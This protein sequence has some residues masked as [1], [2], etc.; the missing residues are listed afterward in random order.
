MLPPI[1]PVKRNGS[2]NTTPKRR[3][4]IGE[5]HLFDIDSIDADRAFLHVVEAE[6]QGNQRGLA[7]AGVADD[8]DGFSG[9]DGEADVAQ[10]PVGLSIETPLPTCRRTNAVTLRLHISR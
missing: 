8:S 7:G 10:H 9:F 2:C 1:V 3:A 6:Q 5:V 4:E